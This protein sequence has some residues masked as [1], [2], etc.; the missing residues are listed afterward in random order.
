MV[1]SLFYKECGCLYVGASKE[2]LRTWILAWMPATCSCKSL[3][4]AS[5]SVKEGLGCQ[6][7]PG[8]TP[9]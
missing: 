3:S 1:R 7:P 4:S 9:P 6:V 5:P 8:L 2:M